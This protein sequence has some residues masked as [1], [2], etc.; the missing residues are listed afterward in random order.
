MRNFFLLVVTFLY[1]SFSFAQIED[2][3]LKHLGAGVVVGGLG[4]LAANKLFN[5]DRYWTWSAAVGGSLAAGLVKE[6]YDQSRGGKFSS[7]DVL[8]TTLGGVISGLAFEIFVNRKQCRRR[9]RPCSCYASHFPTP[10]TYPSKDTLLPIYVGGKSSGSLTASVQA[11]LF[12]Q[13]S[14]N[15]KYNPA[16]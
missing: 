3:N 12:I 2:D 7:S 11:Q 14:T 16:N 9:G 4:A 13:K 5:G 8:Y 1:C 15:L 6:S 10:P